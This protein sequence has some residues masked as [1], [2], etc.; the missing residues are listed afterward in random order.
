MSDTTTAEFNDAENPVPV[1]TGSPIASGWVAGLVIGLLAG[2][3]MWM[4]YR[5]T[6][7]I[8][9]PPAEF[10]QPRMFPSEEF[11]AASRRAFAKV[12]MQHAVVFLGL[13][14]LV[15]S[16]ALAGMELVRRGAWRRLIGATLFGSL[17]AVVFGC[18]AGVLGQLTFVY[19]KL[20]LETSAS[21]RTIL[22]HGLMLAIVGC[23][24]GGVF[25]AAVGRMKL[26]ISC[27]SFGFLAGMLAGVLCPFMAAL[28]FT[29]SNYDMTV[30]ISSQL[31]GFWFIFSSAV[32][33]V[34]IIS[35]ARNKNA[36]AAL[37]DAE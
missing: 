29:K 34:L 19:L 18:I 21:T 37:P 1:Q 8:F 11:V 17:M 6:Y 26:A 32:I 9:Q 35:G 15:L 28:V 25:G 16:L 4:V 33:S 12:E 20:S 36:A 10:Q 7:P 24:V 2:C 23:G 22:T 31:A 13:W 5:T 27:A 14:T 30:P 3:L